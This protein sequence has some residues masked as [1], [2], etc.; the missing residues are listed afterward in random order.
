MNSYLNS[1]L[2]SY[3]NLRIYLFFFFLINFYKLA[4]FNHNIKLQI[5]NNGGI[6]KRN[7]N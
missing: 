7:Q 2:N 6:A 3:N 1:Y 5:I 4:F